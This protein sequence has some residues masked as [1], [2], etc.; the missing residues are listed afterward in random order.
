VGGNYKGREPVPLIMIMNT[1]DA[2][3]KICRGASVPYDRT[4]VLYQVIPNGKS[5]K[6]GFI[7]E[8][9]NILTIEFHGIV[10]QVCSKTGKIYTLAKEFKDQPWI[11]A[12]KTGK[13]NI[14]CMILYC[15]YANPLETGFEGDEEEKQAFLPIAKSK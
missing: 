13:T 2:P 4:G 10:H 1:T 9:A 8:E 11:N 14:I 7:A 6:E 5:T 12:I 15:P 3:V